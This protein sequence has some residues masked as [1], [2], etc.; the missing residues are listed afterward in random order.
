MDTHASDISLRVPADLAYSQILRQALK[1]FLEL[2]PLP[3]CWVYRL[4]LVFDEL[5]MN[6]VKYGSPKGGHVEVRVERHRRG[7]RF[8]VSDEGLGTVTP[9]GLRAILR[10]NKEREGLTH[11]SGRGLA[12]IAAAWTDRLVIRRSTMGGIMVEVDKDFAAAERDILPVT[13]TQQRAASRGTET[14][15]HISEQLLSAESG[16][17]FGRLLDVLKDPLHRKICLDCALVG[18]VSPHRLL[19]LLELYLALALHGADLRWQHVSPALAKKLAHVQ[20]LDK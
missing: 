14:V 6:A 11:V 13:R 5:F 20:V 7:V 16:Q 10:K 15:V 17:E 4:V 2:S 18:D 12:L 8:S 19:R 3:A 1:G 9:A